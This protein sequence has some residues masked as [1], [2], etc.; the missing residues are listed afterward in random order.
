VALASL[1]AWRRICGGLD[2]LGG[3]EL[4]ARIDAVESECAGWPDALRRAPG[5]W[6]RDLLDGRAQPRLRVARSVELTLHGAEVVGDRLAWTDAPE[7]ARATI[8]RVHDDRPGDAGV[9]RWLRSDNFLN[10]E[11]L[12]LAAGITDRGAC[13]LAGDRRIAGVRSL[14]LFRNGIGPAGVA[15]LIDGPRP[16][17]RR[18]LLGR[19]RLGE[20]GVRAL[21]GSTS[22]AGPLL[23][24]LDCDGLDGAAIGALAAAPLLAGVRALN[25]SNNPIGLDGCVAL[26]SSPRLSQLRTLYVHGCGLDDAAVAELLGAP[27]LA[28]LD[29][30]AL[31]D[32]ALSMASIDRL[33]AATALRLG[34]LDICHN[35][36]ISEE[37]AGPVLR[38][39]P[40]LAG[41]RRLCL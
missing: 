9:E 14:G 21:A 3:A 41:L 10:V 24:D 25:L 6:L 30:L 26:A 32:N 17:L 5:R 35:P 38:G 12:T 40:Q 22:I 18:L 15:A 23:L 11:E 1:L 28:G 36:G 13:M 19:N 37:A 7:L 20:A 16:A 34:E 27:W 39:A 2:A 33:A 29:N 4:A 8:V 31:S